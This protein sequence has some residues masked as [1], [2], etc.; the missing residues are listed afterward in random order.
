MAIGGVLRPGNNEERIAG[1]IHARRALLTVAAALVVAGVTLLPAPG[2]SGNPPSPFLCLIACGDESV[3][4]VIGN[5]LLFIPIGWVLRYWL[6][7]AA[8]LVTCLLITVA[9]ESLQAFW[10]VGR[11]PSLRDVLSNGAGGAAGIW[12]FANWLRLLVPST[13]SSRRYGTLALAIWAGTMLVT[14]KGLRPAPTSGPWVGQWAADVRDL[15]PYEGALTRVT[16]AGWT[17]PDSVLP[18]PNPL[19]QAVA[20][21][22]VVLDLVAVSGP[23]PGFTAP[24]FS[25]SDDRGRMQILVAQDRR[26]LL[27]KARTRFET[28]R[29][30]GLSIRLP[31]FPGR[32]PGDTVAVRAVVAGPSWRLEARSGNASARVAVPLTIGLGWVA[33][34]PWRYPVWREWIVMNAIW[35]AALVL[36]WTYWHGRADRRR[37]VFWAVPVLVLGGGLLPPLLGAAPATLTDWTGTVA[38][39]VLGWLLGVWSR[40]RSA[41]A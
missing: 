13:S 36:P 7:P 37:T 14:A 12:L 16:I 26:A 27:L 41:P 24:M 1:M 20:R 11:D 15:A 30:R 21:D 17:P 39:A 9:I 32:A 4:D 33:L 8:T 22:S 5:V 19:R 28:W 38:G 35:L 31:L 40:R 2:P 23:Q 25:V 3:R 34:L 18:E 10:L 6:G 29:L